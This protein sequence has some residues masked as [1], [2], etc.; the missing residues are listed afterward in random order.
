M[1]K[2]HCYRKTKTKKRGRERG[3]DARDESARP[4]KTM[5]FK[6]LD[7]FELPEETWKVATCYREKII[8]AMKGG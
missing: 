4:I 5:R 6:R 2:N 3:A 7:R 1:G 8:T